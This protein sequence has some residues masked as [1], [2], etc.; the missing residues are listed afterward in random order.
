MNNMMIR[1]ATLDDAEAILKIYEPYILNTVI[2]FEYDRIPLED[3]KERMRNIMSKFPWLVCTIDDKVV[4]YAYCSTHLIRAAYAWDC[5]FSIYIS[6]E[7]HR[8]GIATALSKALFQIVKKQGYY[9][10]YSLICVPNINSI[11]LHK[12]LEFKEI[13]TYYNTAYK[14]GQWR[15]VMIMEKTLQV[16][17]GEPVPVIPIDQLDKTTIEEACRL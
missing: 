5:E 2:T 14:F 15:D 10:V 12:K 11:S 7:Y 13:G 8:K 16:P 3:F 6:E 9:N 1:M 17:L 4:G